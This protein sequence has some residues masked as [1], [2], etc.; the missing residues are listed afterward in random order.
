MT[1]RNQ[2]LGRIVPRLSEFIVAVALAAP[3]LSMAQSNLTIYAD[4]LVNGWQDWSYYATR[5]F[6]NTSPVHSGTF[7]QRDR[8]QRLGC[9]Y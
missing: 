1:L 3:A 4:S 8:D 9:H 5:N 7:H 6:A 2:T